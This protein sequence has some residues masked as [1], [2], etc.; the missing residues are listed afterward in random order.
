[1]TNK[2]LDFVLQKPKVIFILVLLLT[3][4]TG[5]LI[6]QIQIDTDPE[7]MLPAHDCRGCC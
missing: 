4:V 1:M 2:T 5:V 3:V 6:P 7:N